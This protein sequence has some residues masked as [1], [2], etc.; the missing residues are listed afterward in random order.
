MWVLIGAFMLAIGLIVLASSLLYPSNNPLSGA[1]ADDMPII[2]RALLYAF[3]HIGILCALITVLGFVALFC[4]IGSFRDISWA[5]KGLLLLSWLFLAI[6]ILAAVG[7]L[8]FILLESHASRLFAAMFTVATIASILLTSS[9]FLA[10]IY[11]FQFS[12]GKKGMRDDSV[13]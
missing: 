2:F 12:V 11:T 3:Q 7:M 10:T 6:N 5:K 9:P 13:V 1:K 8:S 4:G